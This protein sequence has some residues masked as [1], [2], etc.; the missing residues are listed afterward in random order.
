MGPEAGKGILTSQEALSGSRELQARS[1]AP[2]EPKG[3]SESVAPDESRAPY[4]L[5]ALWQVMGLK[6]YQGPTTLGP[7]RSGLGG[8]GGK[9]RGPG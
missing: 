9:S 1:G 7:E 2:E 8:P 3:P 4:G 6:I 5:R